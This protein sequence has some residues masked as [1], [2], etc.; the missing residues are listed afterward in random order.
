MTPADVLKFWFDELKPRQ[1]FKADMALD[2]QI[3]L[4]FG[5][6]H[7]KLSQSVPGAWRAGPR[8]VLA[9]VIVLDQFSRNI[10]RGK[11]SAFANDAAALSLAEEAIDKGFDRAL[12][13]TER[14]FLYMPFQHSE[15]ATTQAR[16]VELFE[17]LR[18]PNA[19]KYA[20][21]HRDI[22]ARFGRFP[23]RNAI[24]GRASTQEEL[25]FLKLPGSSF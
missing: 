4:R 14:Q 10:H 25:A 20:H 2:D 7:G 15:D 24:L 6:V 1:W 16:S 12:S 19:A 18:E 22:I 21:A 8:E 17:S 9:A 23:H 5:A 3:R 11:A 13:I